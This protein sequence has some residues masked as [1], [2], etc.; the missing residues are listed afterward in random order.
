MGRKL[1]VRP[2]PFPGESPAGY[3]IRVAE[4]NGFPSVTAM[5]DGLCIGVADEGWIIA[6]YTRAERYAEILGLLGINN[7]NAI[8]L[9]FDRSGPTAESPR[10]VDGVPYAEQF[11]SEECGAYCPICLA[12]RRYF[13]K[14]WSLK[15]YA[16]CQTHSVRLLRDCYACKEQ[17]SP[18][19]GSLCTCKCGAD[20][21]YGPQIVADGAPV[22]WWMSEMDVGGRRGSDASACLAALFAV[23][24]SDA[25]LELLS[26]ARQWIEQRVVSTELLSLVSGAQSH[27]RVALLPLLQSSSATVQALAQEI[28]RLTP[29]KRSLNAALP[30]RKLTRR[31]AELALGVSAFQMNNLLR[32]GVPATYRLDAGDGWFSARSVSE[33]LYDLTVGEREV[34]CSP[35]AVTRSVASVVK[36]IAE[37]REVTAGFDLALG[38]SSI[39]SA[40]SI[41]PNPESERP[42]EVGVEE[43]AEILGTY[44]EVVRFL[45]RAGW[46]KCR[47]RDHVNRKRLVMD[48]GV[49][50]RFARKYVFAGEIAKRAN[51]GV[52]STAERLMAL[53]VPAVAGPKI[54]GSLVYMF[55]RDL[56]DRID[57]TT[58][59]TMRGYPTVTGRKPTGNATKRESLEMPLAEAAELLGV[60]VQSAKRLVTDRHLRKVK[61]LSRVVLVT[62]GSVQR[63]KRTLGDPEFVPIEAV[64]AILGVGNRALEVTYVQSGLLPVMDLTVSRRVRRVDIAR[65]QE[66]RAN[67]VTAEEAGK[68]LGSHRSHLPNLEARGEIRPISFAKDRSVKFYALADIRKLQT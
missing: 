49:A 21:A 18:L 26:G 5:V 62:R 50:E 42:D 6:A 17:L 10:L 31:Q 53:G 9:S 11:F 58:L 40:C 37:G 64:P 22:D 60:S 24:N 65:L 23:G 28:L 55:E 47:D 45:A 25:S 35:R 39:R 67:Y 41:P 66:M 34:V 2:I 48:R 27:P 43:V 13:R 56:V 61:S 63:F 36:A 16:V 33:M 54:D 3:L 38:I 51:S 32:D 8:L 14:H 15:P 4:G 44:P 59:R 30:E 1:P 68:L 57:L 19:R 12:E 20:L 46:F 29:G 52:T 7:S